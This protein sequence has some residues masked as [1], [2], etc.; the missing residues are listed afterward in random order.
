M[1]GLRLDCLHDS[2]SRYSVVFG[3][4]TGIRGE[5]SEAESGRY[6][7]SLARYGVVSGSPMEIREELVQI[8]WPELSRW[9]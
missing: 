2:L 6:Q 8:E 7:G 5:I 4:H 1:E 9:S 3:S